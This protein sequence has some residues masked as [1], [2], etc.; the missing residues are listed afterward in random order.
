MF[1]RRDWIP[2]RAYPL[3]HSAYEFTDSQGLG[4][5]FEA[6][7][8][9]DWQVHV[10]GREPYEFSEVRRAPFWT[11]KRSRHGRRWYST[12]WRATHGLLRDVGVPCR[13]HPA[14]PDKIDIDWSRAYDEHKPA[15]D[16]LDAH[17]KAYT[18]RADGLVGKVTAPIEYL[19]LGKLSAAE[20]A[21]VDRAVEE[22]IEV[23]Q[24]L[25]PEV[26]AQVDESEWIAAQ[27]MEA[28]RLLAEG[29]RR[30][31][32]VT[33]LAPPPSGSLV[34][35]ISLEVEGIGPVEHRQALNDRWAA[36]LA[37]G[38]QTAVMIDRSDPRRLTLG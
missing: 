28:R 14:K 21:E 18:Q 35:T 16:R 10:E 6:R 1:G 2:G 12:R 29:D 9:V 31:A 30:P 5:W 22:R 27:G 26:Q 32:R 4:D 37:P 17:G 25:P 11:M 34:Y 19:G 15:W 7:L 8:A 36:M 24:R 23:E 38:S 33:A 20:Q 3:S 13:V